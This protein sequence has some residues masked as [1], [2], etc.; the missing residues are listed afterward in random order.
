MVIKHN[1]IVFKGETAQLTMLFG[2]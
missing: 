1:S 2:E